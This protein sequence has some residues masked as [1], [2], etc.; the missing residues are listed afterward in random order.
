MIN[1]ELTKQFVLDVFEI[2]SVFLICR[3]I[4]VWPKQG[5]KV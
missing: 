5:S 4:V 2:L 1:Q 3:V